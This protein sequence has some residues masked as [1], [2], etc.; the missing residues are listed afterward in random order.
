MESLFTAIL[1]DSYSNFIGTIAFI[2]AI[3]CLFISFLVNLRSHATKMFS[4]LL[5]ASL[6]FFASHWSTYFAAI[7]IVATA[8]T[9]L[10]FLQNLAAI[11]RKDENYFNYKKEVLSKEDNIRRKA[12]EVLEEEYVASKTIDDEISKEKKIDISKLQ[13]MS[14]TEMM[15]YAF[16]IEEKTLDFLSQ[17][18]G[19]IERNVRFRKDGESVE[20]DGVIS[21]NNNQKS[22]VFEV[23]W[24]RNAEYSLQLIMHSIRRSKE[25]VEK[26]QKITGIKSEFRLIVVTNTKTG[27]NAD[28]IERFREKAKDENVFLTFL[29]L[30]E[31]GFEVTN[32][33]S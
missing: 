12:E 17:T 10:E 19:N 7:F 3:V 27:L 24:I 22:I 20:F 18:Y 15:K 11:L 9:E 25:L 8:V 30:S 13:D 16:D 4:I 21:E 28:R 14:R 5:V 2:I 1:P 29:S 32:E 31:I 26:Y 23:K 33:N 6:A